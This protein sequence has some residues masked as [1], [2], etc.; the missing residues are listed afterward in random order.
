MNLLSRQSPSFPPVDRA[1]ADPN[2]LLAVGGSLN[3]EWLTA[4][5]ERGIFPWFESD[6]S[7]I[8]WWCPDP[9]AVMVPAQ[10]RI[11]RSLA[12]RLR[13]GGFRATAD[14]A[15]EAVVEGCAGERRAAA[16]GS[17]PQTTGTWIT[18]SMKSAYLE[19]HRLGL[20]HSIE[21]WLDG[22]LAGGLYGVSLG[23]LFFGESM[24]SRVPDASKVALCHL[25]R[26]LQ[27]WGFWLIDCQ[28]ANPHLTRMGAVPLPRAEFMRIIER[29][30]SE[31]TRRGPW[32]LDPVPAGSWKKQP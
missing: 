11:T 16:G 2:G 5:Y 24:F 23:R 6:A 26:R 20:A 32:H 1:L 22:R 13:N 12:K 4:A 31:P 3:A 27:S 17:D 28:I 10:V 14:A 30:A 21:V 18:A 8:L 25:A 15:F 19:L 29:N 7:P 9:R